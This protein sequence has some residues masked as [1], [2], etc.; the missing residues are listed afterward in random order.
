MAQCVGHCGN[1]GLL[2]SRDGVELFTEYDG[3]CADCWAKLTPEKRAILRGN[4]PP[5]KEIVEHRTV[6]YPTVSAARRWG[7]RVWRL[8]LTGAVVYLFW[9]RH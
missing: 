3:Y 9:H 2:T 8:I 6:V 7:T 5:V 1:Q 4:E